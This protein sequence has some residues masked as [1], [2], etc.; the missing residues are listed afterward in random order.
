MLGAGERL[1][2]KD[3]FGGAISDQGRQGK[4]CIAEGA[5]NGRRERG[6]S[7]TERELEIEAESSAEG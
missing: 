5:E 3:F 4:A 2:G 7:G 1:R 6:G